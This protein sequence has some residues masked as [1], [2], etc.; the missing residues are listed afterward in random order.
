MPFLKTLDLLAAI[1]TRLAALTAPDGSPLFVQVEFF[2][3]HQLR[4]AINRLAV[5]EGRLCFIVPSGETYTTDKRGGVVL[6]AQ[7]IAEFDLLICDRDW[8]DQG[9]AAV[10][11]SAE[12]LGVL[13]MKETVLDALIG[14]DLGLPAY[15]CLVPTQGDFI[16]VSLDQAKDSPGRECWVQSFSTLAGETRVGRAS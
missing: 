16:Q 10:F 13:A 4:D 3:T 2:D 11:G 8:A 12:N 6:F 1:K 7:R 14:N 15:V 5:A 9:Q